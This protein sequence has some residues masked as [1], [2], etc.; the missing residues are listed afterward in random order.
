MERALLE[1]ELKPLRVSQLEDEEELS[2][3]MTASDEMD[4]RHKKERE[5]DQQAIQVRIFTIFNSLL[6]PLLK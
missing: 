5:N 6:P 2:R 3:L 1:G 4:D